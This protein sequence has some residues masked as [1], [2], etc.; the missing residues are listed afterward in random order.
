M[1]LLPLGLRIQILQRQRPDSLIPADLN[2]RIVDP[3]LWDLGSDTDHLL[4]NPGCHTRSAGLRRC[5]F[6]ME[7]CVK[8]PVESAMTFGRG[9]LLSLSLQEVKL[10]SAQLRWPSDSHRESGRFARIDSQKKSLF[11]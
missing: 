9:S 7:Q 10:K 1:V 4:R 3:Q 5:D 6:P 8:I 11:S 2:L